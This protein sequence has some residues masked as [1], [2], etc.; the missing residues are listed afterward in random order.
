[1]KISV[2]IPSFNSEKFIAEALQSIVSQ[3]YPDTEVILIDGGSKDDTVEIAKGFK[4]VTKI[5]SEPDKG[6]SD[7]LNKGFAIATGD[8]FY[9]LNS[10]DLICEGAFNAVLELFSKSPE[11]TICYGNWKSVDESGRTLMEYFALKP[12]LP[13]FPSENLKSY[14]QSLFWKRSVHNK[15]PGFDTELSRLMDNDMILW[16]LLNE[17]LENWIYCNKFLGKF[18]IHGNQKTALTMDERHFFEER[19]LEKK[20]GFAPSSSITGKK[21]RLEYRFRQLFNCL[22]KGGFFYTLTCFSEGFRKRKRLF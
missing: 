3:N 4:I 19:L 8:V 14:N 6:Q 9:W 15:F 11:K 5:I 21:Y 22:R 17:D 16:F 20:Y 18:R 13:R 1:M 2:V 12:V 7:A 10:D